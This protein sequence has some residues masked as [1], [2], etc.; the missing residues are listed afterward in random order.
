MNKAVAN[1]LCCTVLGLTL[2][3]CGSSSRPGKASDAGEDGGG[4]MD[5][6]SSGFIRRRDAQVTSG[7][8][9]PSC[10]RFAQNSCSAGTECRIVI[11]RSADAGQFTIYSGC[12]EGVAARKLGDPCDS[13]GGQT[14]QYKAAGLT[15]EVYVDPCGEGQYCAMDPKV[16]GH[17]SCQLSCE[18]GRFQGENTTPC[19]SANQY[20][21]LGVA[22]ATPLEEVCRD[23][24]ACDPVNQVGCASGFGC[25]LRLGDTGTSVLTVC[26]PTADMPIA[27]GELCMY[28][29]DCT[30]GSS[31][32][33]PTRTPQSRWQQSDLICRRSCSASSSGSDAGDEDG[34]TGGGTCSR[35]QSCVSCEGSGL[36]FSSGSSSIGQCE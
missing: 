35:R 23:A 32:F 2:A 18:S 27:D 7:D 8:A 21:A 12:V 33:G 4:T 1:M 25:Y 13:F 17:N 11:R 29:N 22:N 26:Q 36:T 24:D 6:G 20:C 19:P 15:D 14:T 9:I 16:R 10:D 28:V 5:A 3:A 31:C 30:P 34:G